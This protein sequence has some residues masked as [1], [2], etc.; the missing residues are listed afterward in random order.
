MIS[1][2]RMAELRKELNV[3]HLVLFSIDG[4]GAQNV[5]T[6]GKSENQAIQAADYGNN[7]KK[8]LGFPD[9]MSD[10]KPIDRTCSNCDFFENDRGFGF[11]EGTCYF[12]V[13]TKNVH[14]ERKAC[15]DFIS[16]Y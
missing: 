4:K 10:S 16:K 6:H 5:A 14:F 11:V 12:D 13:P 2:K 8:H 1:V 15:K 7:L 9:K 3:T